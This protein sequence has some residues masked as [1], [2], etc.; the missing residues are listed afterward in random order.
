MLK[1]PEQVLSLIMAEA[2]LFSREKA[3]ETLE[4]ILNEFYT[5]GWDDRGFADNAQKNNNNL[6]KF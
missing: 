3:L 1:T 4:D 2:Q 5:A 6:R